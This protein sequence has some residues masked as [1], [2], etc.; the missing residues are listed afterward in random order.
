MTTALQPSRP[1]DGL[2]RLFQQTLDL[3]FPPACAGCGA[4]GQPLCPVCSQ[5]VE[6]L[7]ATICGHCGRPQPAPTALCANC[8]RAPGQIRLARAAALHTAPLREAIHALK[9]AQRPEL[10]P[11]LGRYLVAAMQTPPW[12][13]LPTPIDAVVPVPLHPSRYQER[14]YNQSELLAAVLCGQMG[15]ALRPAWLERVRSTP[16]QVGLNA[17]ER[18]QN[19][20]DAFV[21]H[22]AVAG[23]VLLFVDDVYTT[24]ATLRECARAAISAGAAAVYALTLAIPAGEDMT[25]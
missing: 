13:H 18:Q 25:R 16:P 11:Y 6:A 20:A 12:T 14:G 22:S 10:A 7:P 24:G 15:L 19:V 1:R 4:L 23:R 5:Q 21:A 3:F 2:Q 9:Y 8:R 17:A